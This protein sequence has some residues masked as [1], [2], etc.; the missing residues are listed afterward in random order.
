MSFIFA[1]LKQHNIHPAT[2]PQDSQRTPPLPSF[3]KPQANI[4]KHNKQQTSIHHNKSHAFLVNLIY[5]NTRNKKCFANNNLQTHSSQPPF[6]NRFYTTK[7]AFLG[8]FQ[9]NYKYIM[10]FCRSFANLYLTQRITDRTQI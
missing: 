5:I 8:K 9:M 1:R 6:P 10:Y 7:N 4:R 3:Y 2:S